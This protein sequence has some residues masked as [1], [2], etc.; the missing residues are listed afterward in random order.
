[1]HPLLLARLSDASELPHALVFLIASYFD[2]QPIAWKVLHKIAFSLPKSPTSSE[3]YYF[4]HFF[5]NVLH[6]AT[7]SQGF[8]GG[9]G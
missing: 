4:Q 8:K 7:T 2:H 9:Y 3:R 6:S 1:M 5:N